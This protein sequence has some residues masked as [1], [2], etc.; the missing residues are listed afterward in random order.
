[1]KLCKL[2]FADDLL[3]FCKAEVNSI[4][5]LL[6]VINIFA[7]ASVM[8]LS[9]AKSQMVVAGVSSSLQTQLFELIGL[10]EGRM[11][12]KYLGM[13]ITSGRHSSSNC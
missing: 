3:L 12:F 8:Q 7:E 13:L 11:T 4:K 6:D 9:Q 10:K 1:M 2:S 5:Y